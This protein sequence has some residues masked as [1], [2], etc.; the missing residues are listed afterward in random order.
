MVTKLD[1][2]QLSEN[3]VIL[4][5]LDKR[6]PEAVWRGRVPS[7]GTVPEEFPTY[8]GKLEIFKCTKKSGLFNKEK[9]EVEKSYKESYS[10]D[11]WIKAYKG[12]SL[13]YILEL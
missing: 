6:G 7:Q 5:S 10:K 2:E 1:R 13:R 9:L 11:E 12:I 8:L 3:C 4:I